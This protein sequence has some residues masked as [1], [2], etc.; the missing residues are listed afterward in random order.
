MSA[1]I[2]WMAAEAE[3][4]EHGIPSFT[5]IAHVSQNRRDPSTRSACSGQA[6]GHP[7]DLGHPPV[8]PQEKRGAGH[9]HP[10]FDPRELPAHQFPARPAQEERAGTEAMEDPEREQEWRI[11]R[12]RTVAMLRRYMRYAIETGRLPSVLGRE[13]FR[14][15]VTSYTVVT[16]EDRVIFVHDMEMCLARLD[17]F[18]R[19]VLSR[20]VLQEYEQEEAAH[21]L[22]CT[23][24]T[25][26]RK[27]VEAL[28]RLKD[29]LLEVGLLEGIGS[30]GK[31][32]CQEGE[33]GNY[34][35]SDCEEEK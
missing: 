14:A 34:F 12:R 23:R 25:V 15:R 32:S 10:G 17:E 21:L 8:F 27:L 5:G 3:R 33:R 13:F 11:Y 1:V 28:D 7:A 16:F 9:A 20:V 6:P 2:E 18:S 30:G 22:G 31:N 35:V 29:I 19:R 4:P 24:M 26:H